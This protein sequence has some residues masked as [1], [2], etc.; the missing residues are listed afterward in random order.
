MHLSPWILPAVYF[1]PCVVA[2]YPYQ[3]EEKTGPVSKGDDKNARRSSIGEILVGSGLS[4]REEKGEVPTLNIR[5]RA[6]RVGDVR[7]AMSASLS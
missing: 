1:S 7:L 6:P 4:P 3:A 5:R 2:F